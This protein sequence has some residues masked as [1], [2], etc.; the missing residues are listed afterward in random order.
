MRAQFLHM[1]NNK[2]AA[3]A[4]TKFRSKDS[5][6]RI[7]PSCKVLKYLDYFK[8]WDNYLLSG[9]EGVALSYADARVILER[10]FYDDNKFSQVRHFCPCSCSL[11]TLNHHGVPYFFVRLFL[12]SL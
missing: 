10:S 6:V 12:Y 9:S 4:L 5:Q 1:D 7:H 3:G 2:Q 8:M 11:C